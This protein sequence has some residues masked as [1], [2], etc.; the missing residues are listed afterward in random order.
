M[1]GSELDSYIEKML[2]D[3]VRYIGVFTSDEVG[4][5]RIYN[6]RSIPIVFIANTLKKI[7]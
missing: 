4:M 7:R 2:G 5:M 3:R 1:D 6:N